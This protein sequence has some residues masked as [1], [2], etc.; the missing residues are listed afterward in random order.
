M[1]FPVLSW[2]RNRVSAD[3]F[4]DKPKV[5]RRNPVS[6]PHFPYTLNPT[7]YLMP[8]SRSPTPG[9]E[10][11]SRAHRSQEPRNCQIQPVPPVPKI[12]PPKIIP[13]KIPKLRE[14]IIPRSPSGFPGR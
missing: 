7:P 12:I 5:L 3:N 6:S 14:S 8:I 13:P 2:R 1:N 4:G 10:R 9:E 11:H